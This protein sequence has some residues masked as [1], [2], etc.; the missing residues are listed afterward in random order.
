MSATATTHYNP[1][2]GPG[3]TW[4]FTTPTGK[5]DGFLSRIDALRTAATT[6]RQDRHEAETGKG[7]IAVVLAKFFTATTEVNP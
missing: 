1:Q 5:C 2:P 6:E 3:G 7:P 4:L